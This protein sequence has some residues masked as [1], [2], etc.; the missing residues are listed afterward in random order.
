M[1]RVCWCVQLPE[2]TTWQDRLDV[3]LSDLVA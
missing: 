1:Q 3:V 2:A